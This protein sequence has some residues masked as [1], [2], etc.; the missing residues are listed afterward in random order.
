LTKVLAIELVTAA[1]GIDL[2]TP[3][4]PA[5]GTAAARDALRR[6]GVPGPGP[7]RPLSPELEAAAQLVGDGTILAA[8]EQEV[9]A[10]G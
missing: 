4:L 6:N 10:L 9:G 2:R 7:D 8:V 1:R 5:R 3:L